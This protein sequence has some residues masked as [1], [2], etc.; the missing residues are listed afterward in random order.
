MAFDVVMM[1]V[2]PTGA[3]NIL[4]RTARAVD[5]GAHAVEGARIV[6]KTDEIASKAWSGGKKGKVTPYE[7]GTVNDLRNR[8]VSGDLAIHHVGQQ[9]PAKQVIPRYN[10]KTAPGIAIPTEEHTRIPTL[11]GEYSGSPR[12]L[13]AKDIRDLRTY[14]KAPNSA[15]KELIQLNKQIYPE[16]FRK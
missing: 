10:P 11:K 2:E 16:A 14:T 1:V 3:A 7:V 4:A 8:S 15:L 13:L 6:G 12:N 5:I 9:H